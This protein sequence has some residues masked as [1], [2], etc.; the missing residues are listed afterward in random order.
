M[1]HMQLTY[2]QYAEE[3]AHMFKREGF[4]VNVDSVRKKISKYKEC[5]V[6][7]VIDAFNR[8]GVKN[9]LNYMNF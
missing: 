9:C 5:E 7:R 2:T 8:F 3:I 1:V 4:D 6:Q